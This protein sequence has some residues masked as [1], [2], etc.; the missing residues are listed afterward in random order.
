MSK[1]LPF[2]ILA[3]S[4][5]IA[6]PLI[7]LTS[8]DSGEI[9]NADSS[10][11]D[12]GAR[13][14]EAELQASPASTAV[15]PQFLLAGDT[16]LHNVPFGGIVQ[17]YGLGFQDSD[18]EIIVD[19][20]GQIS[21]I[22][23]DSV[24]P[25]TGYIYDPDNLGFVLQEQNAFPGNFTVEGIRN[26]FEARMEAIELVPFAQIGSLADAI[27]GDFTSAEAS[28]IYEVAVE[29]IGLVGSDRG[30]FSFATLGGE[31][32]TDAT[33]RIS[34]TITYAPSST[35]ATLLSTGQIRGTVTIEDE[36][37]NLRVLLPHDGRG[38]VLALEPASA[39]RNNNTIVDYNGIVVNTVRNSGSFV[40]TPDSASF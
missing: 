24:T 9:D 27:L 23:G 22:E 39:V 15:M 7:G 40:Y 16:F 36:I 12:L 31:N 4:T 33:V 26:N 18:G 1:K 17:E 20:A 29:S 13:Y 3:M 21:T 8:C 6:L 32:L 25:N 38:R 5:M 37:V 28:R 2:K 14:D 11:F 10:A 30:Q 34:R 19:S 35:N